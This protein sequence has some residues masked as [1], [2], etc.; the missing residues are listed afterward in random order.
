MSRLFLIAW[1]ALAVGAR[2]N[3][4]PRLDVWS[5]VGPGGGGA[6]FTPTVS[7]HDPNVV[8]VACDMTGTYISKDG[9]ISWRMFN[10]RGRSSLLVFDPVDPDVIYVKT[11]GLW[12]SADRGDTWNL[13]LP[14]PSTVT[15]IEMPDDH[16]SER[17]VTNG[18]AP[19][20]L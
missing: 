5:V 7:P 17:L 8:L 12:R 1:C 19:E 14:D 16:A 9:G 6:Q 15:A 18:A 2:V 11:I 10:L 20:S 13:V 4:A 3:A